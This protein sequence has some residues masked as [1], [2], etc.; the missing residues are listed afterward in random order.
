MV[1]AN[2]Q[3]ESANMQRRFYADNNTL[4][5]L[6]K[7]SDQI[8]NLKSVAKEFEAIFL[9]MAIKSMR[10]AGKS[11]KSDLMSS[12]AEDT[13]QEMYDSQLSLHLSSSSSIGIAEAIVRQFSQNFATNNS[14]DAK[15]QEVSVLPAEAV[16]KSL[17]H[18]LVVDNGNIN[19][20]DSVHEPAQ[21]EIFEPHDFVEKVWSGIKEVAKSID[22][23]PKMM[24]AQA[25]H[26]TGWGRFIPKIST[27]ELANNLF[28]IKADESWH[29]SSI[30]AKTTE[31]EDGVV[32]QQKEKFRT[33]GNVRTSM[34]DYVDFV[35]NNPRYEKALASNNG[36]EYIKEL[37][38]AGYAT[39]PN[40]SDKVLNI[41]NGDRLE[42]LLNH[43]DER[44]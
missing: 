22:I 4:S 14:D 1:D 6:N 33:Y 38:K 37:H 31:V 23:D 12:S 3:I 21:K 40:Y 17:S 5:S 15:G 35:S 13:Y 16:E 2:L 9:Q 24:L 43:I 11:M 29:G 26:E 42:S 8:E 20:I 7:N 10:D 27:G 44:G 25:I 30:V 34:E 28:G 36:V 39:D 18:N 19:H 41:Y 32:K